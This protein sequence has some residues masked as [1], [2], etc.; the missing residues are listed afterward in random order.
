MWY[1]TGSVPRPFRK[2]T[3]RPPPA[4]LPESLRYTY[5]LLKQPWVSGRERA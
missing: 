5:K 3:A 4:E 1:Y 2:S